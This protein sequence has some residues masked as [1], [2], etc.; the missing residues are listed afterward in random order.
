[1]NYQEKMEEERQIWRKRISDLKA[2]G[3][4]VAQYGK[5]N[6]LSVHQIYYWKAKFSEIQNESSPPPKSKAASPVV[7]IISRV[8]GK[9]SKLP[10]PKW[11]AELIK[12][13]HEVF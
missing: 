4:T 6:A 8:E 1:M 11:V 5:A 3:V 10:D 13:L 7:K 9:S 12:A 2:S